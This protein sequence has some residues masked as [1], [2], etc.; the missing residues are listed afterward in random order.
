MAGQTGDVVQGVSSGCVF[1]SG[2]LSLSG[3][4]CTPNR[5]R[6]FGYSFSGLAITPVCS[7]MMP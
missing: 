3:S 4:G 5:W 2:A 1:C 7:A 6:G